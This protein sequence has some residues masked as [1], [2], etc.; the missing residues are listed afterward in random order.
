MSDFFNGQPK[1]CWF[2]GQSPKSDKNSPDIFGAKLNCA[3]MLIQPFSN[4]WT[5][6][7][8]KIVFCAYF[9]RFGKINNF[10]E[11]IFQFEP[12][13]VEKTQFFYNNTTRFGWFPPKKPEK[14]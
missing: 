11:E 1:I 3:T 8:K 13:F 2:E 5:T 14:P 12:F 6:C 10:V 4:K 9:I 7:L